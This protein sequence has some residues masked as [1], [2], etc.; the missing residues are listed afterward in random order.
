MSN[1]RD[2]GRQARLLITIRVTEEERE[3]LHRM[4][5]R[6]GLSTN[7]W[8]R[9]VLSLGQLERP[10]PPMSEPVRRKMAENGRRG[11]AK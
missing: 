8:I 11:G 7:A 6:E 5:R 1:S 4:A 3:K 10:H 9:Q 2:A